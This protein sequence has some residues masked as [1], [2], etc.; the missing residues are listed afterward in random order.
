M[1]SNAASQTGTEVKAAK[2]GRRYDI[3]WLR[4][5]AVLLLFPF[6]TARIFDTWLPFYVK[7]A[8]ASDALTYFIFYLN[9]W[10]M[11]LL[12]LLAGASTWFA[13]GFRSAG[14]YT[15]ERFI[16]GFS[17]KLGSYVVSLGF[18][19]SYGWLYS[20]ASDHKDRLVAA[21]HPKGV[22]HP[23]I[24]LSTPSG[25]WPGLCFFFGSFGLSRRPQSA[26]NSSR[27]S[28]SVCN[29]VQRRRHRFSI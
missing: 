28:Y 22:T 18:A 25:Y 17:D 15:K 11:P 14:Q 12:F 23:K 21:N 2:P 20:L 26:G 16:C 10:H 1:Q 5:L 27:L 19:S 24:S 13:L 8:A 4:V 29:D 6:H 3:D 9:P 7:N